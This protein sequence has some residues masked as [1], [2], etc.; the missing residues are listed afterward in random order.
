MIA[1]GRKASI[2]AAIAWSAFE[3]SVTS[4]DEDCGQAGLSARHRLSCQLTRLAY[5]GGL[6]IP[7]ALK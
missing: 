7:L 2:S 3:G 4:R 5:S 1:K 6:P